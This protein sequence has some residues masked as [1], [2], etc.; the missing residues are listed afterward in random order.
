MES[1]HAPKLK[2]M[3]EDVTI[4]NSSTLPVTGTCSSESP[5]ERW[6]RRLL[7]LAARWHSDRLRSAL[8][9]G[10]ILQLVD[11]AREVVI[12]A[13]RQGE[14]SRRDDRAIGHLEARELQE[15]RQR[16]RSASE[17]GEADL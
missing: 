4:A 17:K 11:C 14:L 3:D 1:L 8:P 6:R 9:S 10:R 13:G 5:W 12:G 16:D 2:C 7:L 15:L